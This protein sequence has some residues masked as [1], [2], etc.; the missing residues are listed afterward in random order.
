[1]EKISI[2]IFWSLIASTLIFL[3]NKNKDLYRND[4]DGLFRNLQNP[5]IDFT[6]Y[7]NKCKN[8]NGNLIYQAQS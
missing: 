5:K 6:D 1:M 2:L 8:P 7:L 4:S 3:I